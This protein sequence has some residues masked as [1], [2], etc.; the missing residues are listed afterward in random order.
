M[1]RLLVGALLGAG[2][3]YLLPTLQAKFV[4]VEGGTV[5]TGTCV[6]LDVETLQAHLGVST[7]RPYVTALEDVA[8]LELFASRQS[9]AMMKAADDLPTAVRFARQ[10]TTKASEALWKSTCDNVHVSTTVLKKVEEIIPRVQDWVDRAVSNVD[11][12]CDEIKNG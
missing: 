4:V 3:A 1:M 5:L 10:A 6:A 12:Y 7:T 11:I 8:K 9:D 2:A